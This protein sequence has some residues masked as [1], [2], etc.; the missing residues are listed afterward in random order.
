MKSVVMIGC[1]A[2]CVSIAANPAPVLS[3]RLRAN[4]TDTR[5]CWLKSFRS[6][7]EHPGCCDEIWFSTGG[8][9]PSLDWHRARAQV[10]AGAVSDVTE[11]GIVPSLQFQATLGHG[12]NTVSD[13]RLFEQKTWTGWTDWNGTETKFCNCPR[14]PAFLDYLREV[15]AIYAP[16]HFHAVWIDDDL[17]IAYHHP[18]K[19]FGR[20]SG[21]W[22]ETCLQAFNEETGMNWTRTQLAEAIKTDDALSARWRKFSIDGLCLVTRTLAETFH[23]HSPE[24]MLALQ[25]ASGEENIDQARAVLTILHEVSGLPVGCRPGGGEY[26]D[27]D[28]NGILLKSIRT[29]WFWTHLADLDF[30]TVATPEIES[31]PRTYYSRSPQGAVM[32][33][34]TALMYGMNAVSFFISNC[35]QEEPSLYGRTYWKAFAEASPVLRAYARAI[36]G[37]EA[38]GFSIPGKPSIGIRRAAIPVLAGPG[39]SLGVLD[40]ATCAIKLQEQ[41]SARVQK[42]RD[43]LDRRAGGL[44][45]VVRSPFVGL[46]QV[47]VEPGGR[48]RTVALMNTRI[49]E[50]GPV[51]LLLRNVPEDWKSIQWNEMSRPSRTLPL[52]RTEEGARVVVPSIGPWNG[53]FLTGWNGQ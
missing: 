8:G 45:A 10:I 34:F 17:R 53:G 44:P 41:T 20:H 1:L 47:H 6:I 38:V 31:W 29:G 22:C 46:L 3:M 42:L 32:E 24:T 43:D 7:A 16:L 51:E 52:T 27:D 37:C 11:R 28:P 21:C 18:A 36:D 13:P 49:S 33:G 12:D 26:Y 5:E 9:V 48:L 39:R 50:Q 23:K 14:Q 2:A 15:A 35:A 30:I 25:H 19:S 4:E 40:P